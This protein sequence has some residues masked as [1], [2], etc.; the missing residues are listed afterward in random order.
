MNTALNHQEHTK[1]KSLTTCSIE[2]TLPGQHPI[3]PTLNHSFTNSL[4]QYIAQD[5]ANYNHTYSIVSSI[6]YE[7][8]ENAL[9]FNALKKAPI[10][11]AIKKK[12]TTL[13]IQTSNI[14]TK[15][16]LKN[17]KKTIQDIKSSKN[18]TQL[19]LKNIINHVKTPSKQAQIGL[20]GLVK[21]YNITI[22]ALITKI[23][24]T[25]Y[26]KIELSAQFCDTIFECN[27]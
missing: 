25:N 14:S 23:N 26:Y 3:N 1:Q 15:T 24:Q 20:I 22:D 8:I 13:T 12:E 5:Y 19:F 4:S 17:L 18:L 9:N 10:S 2:V 6:I 11:I 16:N 27:N 7:L 21:N